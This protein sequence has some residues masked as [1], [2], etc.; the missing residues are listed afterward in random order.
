SSL[1]K[2]GPSPASVRGG[3]VMRAIIPPVGARFPT[4]LQGLYH[5]GAHR[6]LDR[7]DN[8]TAGSFLHGGF[9]AEEGKLKRET[10]AYIER[11]IAA[12]LT[13]EKVELVKRYGLKWESV[14]DRTFRP[15]GG[16]ES[17]KKRMQ[18]DY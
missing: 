1:P 17:F 9:I 7:G 10:K 16:L 6:S 5:A 8:R 14:A 3:Y 15:N 4:A 13:G 18:G 12:P 11:L 2:T